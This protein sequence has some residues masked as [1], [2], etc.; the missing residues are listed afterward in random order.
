VKTTKAAYQ[1]FGAGLHGV[2][3]NPGEVPLEPG[4]VYYI[5]WTNPTGF[6]PYI[7]DQP[8]DAYAD[9]AGYQ[10]GALK[11]GGTVDV[12]KTIVVYT[13]RGG[14]LR[15]KV[16]DSQSG[17]G[18]AGATVTAAPLGRASQAG[19]GGDY[20]IR[21]VPPGTYTVTA[22]MAGFASKSQSGVAV[23]EGETVAVDFALAR[24][25]CVFV[26]NNGGFE[27][28]LA[29][30][31]R[32]GKAKSSN[33]GPGW[34]GGIDPAEGAKFWGN[35]VNGAALGSGGAY[36]RFCAE[37]GHRFRAKV[38]SNIYWIDG[39]QNGARSRIGLHPAGGTEPDLQ[40]IWSP[41]DRQPLTKKVGWREIQVEA[42]ASGP[43]MTVFLDFEQRDASSPPPGSQ[44]RI[45]CFDGA[46]LED[47][48]AAVSPRFDRG[49]CSG[50]RAIDLTDAIALLS[51][52][53]QGAEEPRCLSA[54]DSND[55]GT[56][57]LSDAVRT[58]GHL[59]LGGEA[60]RAPRGACGE[61]PTADAL[62]CVQF[63][64]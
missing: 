9:G 51:H 36:Q 25:P 33:P 38:S 55:D 30:W 40:V 16:T 26:F 57:D 49:D 46:S 37:P 63:D 48:D 28:A 58:L 6:N 2:S 43:V 18:L 24:V 29:G 23:A 52:L 11:L 22:A 13:G 62:G 42:R 21:E 17:L 64:C 54:C 44:W 60:L 50:D 59:F 34:F 5:E 12:S 53:F 1:A 14:T 8:A 32:Y 7:F 15:G 31:T 3:Y 35:E 10:N 61:D 47:L 27:Q 45:N 4:A 19:A 41:W 39:D 20:A 56:L